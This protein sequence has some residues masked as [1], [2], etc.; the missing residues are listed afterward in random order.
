MKALGEDSHLQAREGG[1]EQLMALR[2][3]QP[4]PHFDFGFL[5]SRAVRE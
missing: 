1:L 2:R 4:C 5:A 3:N